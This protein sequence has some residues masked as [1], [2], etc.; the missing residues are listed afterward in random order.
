M[1]KGKLK[2]TGNFTVMNY[3]LKGFWFGSLYLSPLFANDVELL[4]YLNLA[5]KNRT[6]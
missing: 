5:Q 6:K 1:M 2:T 3:V 4:K